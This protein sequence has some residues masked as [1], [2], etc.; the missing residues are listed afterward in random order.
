MQCNLRVV[1]KLFALTIDSYIH[2]TIVQTIHLSYN[3]FTAVVTVWGRHGSL[4][5]NTQT[6][7][8]YFSNG[9]SHGVRQIDLLTGKVSTLCGC[10]DKPAYVSGKGKNARFNLVTGLALDQRTN[11]LYVADSLNHILRTV[12]LS[13]EVENKVTT[14]YGTIG[15]FGHVEGIGRHALFH[16][17]KGLALDKCSNH[18]YVADWGNDLIKKIILDTNYVTTL[19]G[20]EKQRGHVDGSLVNATFRRPSILEWNPSTCELYVGEKRRIRVVSL[21]TNMVSTLYVGGKGFSP[22]AM[23]LALDYSCLFITDDFHVIWK[24]SL[25]ENRGEIH[26]LCGELKSGGCVNGVDSQFLRPNGITIDPTLGH[27]YVM[28]YNIQ[29]RKITIRN[30]N[31]SEIAQES[32]TKKERKLK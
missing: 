2:T 10:L 13:T 31:Q 25:L 3:N 8:M 16:T 5:M 19:C 9:V 28:D 11:I 30:H 23:T 29:L 17:P 1:C 32:Q 4:V 20:K 12:D 6:R 24:L 18:L 14:R 22:T 7:R 21:K 15:I 26:L 27:I